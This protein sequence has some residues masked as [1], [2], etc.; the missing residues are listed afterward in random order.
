MYEPQS[1]CYACSHG[2]TV[3]PVVCASKH[4]WLVVDLMPTLLALVDQAPPVP[5]D[6]RSVA[7]AILNAQEAEAQPNLR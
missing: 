7:E 6:G 1:E 5:I 3:C 4:L 2:L